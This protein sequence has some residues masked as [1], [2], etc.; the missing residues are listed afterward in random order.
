M[1][2]KLFFSFLVIISAFFTLS[3]GRSDFDPSYLPDAG[4]DASSDSDVDSD[5][6]EE[7]CGNGILEEELNEECDNGIYNSD[8]GGASCRTNCILA[9]CGDGITDPLTEECDEGD[10][11][12]NE[13]GAICRTDCTNGG[14][15]DDILDPDEECDE[16]ALNSDAPGAVCRTNCIIP[17]C[18]DGI[19]DPDEE[20]DDA[21]DIDTDM[22]TNSCTDAHCGDGIILAGVE[23][24]DDGNNF[25]DILCSSDCSAGCGDGILDVY[26]GEKCDDG[27]LNSDELPGACRTDC[28]HAHCGD[29]IWDD[30]GFCLATPGIL[31]VSG[32]PHSL[33]YG[34]VDGD[35][36]TD[37]ILLTSTS[38]FF[39][40]GSSEGYILTWSRSGLTT[41][42]SPVLGDFDNDGTMDLTAV[43]PTTKKLVFFK[44]VDGLPFS[45]ST[46]VRYTIDASTPDASV[47]GD[48]NDDGVIDLAVIIPYSDKVVFMSAASG[49][50][51]AVSSVTT[52]QRPFSISSNRYDVNESD[53]F[54]VACFVSGNIQ[55]FKN[56]GGYTFSLINLNSADFPIDIKSKDMNNDGRIDLVVLKKNQSPALPSIT[57]F[58]SKPNGSFSPDFNVN[59]LPSSS[60][61]IAVSDYDR[62]YINDVVVSTDTGF[63]VYK[64]SG[65]GSLSYHTQIVWPVNPGKFIWADL[66]GDF[67][68]DLVTSGGVPSGFITTDDPV[69]LP[70]PQTVSIE[71]NATTA[72]VNDFDGDNNGDTAFTTADGRI[73][74]LSGNGTGGF[75]V[76]QTINYE[77]IS[78]VYSADLYDDAHADIFAVSP[79]GIDI[80]SN[81]SN[82]FSTAGIIDISGETVIGAVT[83]ADFNGD[84]YEDAAFALSNGNI[85]IV[86][87]GVTHQT[88]TVSAGSSPISITGLDLNNDGT[89]ELFILNSDGSIFAAVHN[90]GNFISTSIGTTSATGSSSIAG[91]YAGTSDSPRP[92]L[93]VF[94][95]STQNLEVWEFDTLME[96]V[97]LYSTSSFG[98]IPIDIFQTD[99]DND[100]LLDAIALCQDGYQLKLVH[101]DTSG[102]IVTNGKIRST[103]YGSS[104]CSSGILDSDT[105]SDIICFHSNQKL[106]SLI[107]TP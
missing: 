99:H 34:D 20:C 28:R 43:E 33:T 75:S 81:D 1:K 106:S 62:N 76:N 105:V 80:L 68:A 78:S 47:A 59:N 2:S 82:I 13:P 5:V 24:C 9:H 69:S 90:S 45:F 101:S 18:G 36:F 91:V 19:I 65:N 70:L 83:G 104:V 29:N 63:M 25:D 103:I 12:S 48:F 17:G 107:T 26:R 77:N 92:A 102:D 3:C 51:S 50:F 55:L 41:P 44:G 73:I 22:C 57:V 88:H 60:T 54:A 27:A 97:F 8:E 30:D 31:S 37:L 61:K 94:N 86:T 35:G 38:A 93:A 49:T 89:T 96:S 74:L 39:Y 32:T 14:C 6:I 95:S 42:I 53:D 79:T 85:V 4:N 15:G 98:C 58:I 71:T 52:C 66:D 10:E 56:N 72:T 7:G 87:G 11:N 21:N 16:G 64:N 67:I 100:G 46:P 23:V 84:L 40:R